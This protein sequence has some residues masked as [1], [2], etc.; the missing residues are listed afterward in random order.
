MP[1]ELSRRYEVHSRLFYDTLI[2]DPRSFTDKFFRQNV[3]KV[4]PQKDVP[5]QDRKQ[6]AAVWLVVGEDDFKYQPGEHNGDKPVIT[7][8]N[9][10]SPDP[11]RPGQNYIVAR[12]DKRVHSEAIIHN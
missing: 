7:T 10:F 2:R 8:S 6:F 9:S 5:G 1:P 3:I 11:T 12:P 4:E